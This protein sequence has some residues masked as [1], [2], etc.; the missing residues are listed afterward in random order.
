MTLVLARALLSI[1]KSRTRSRTRPRIY[2]CLF[3]QGGI[4][5]VLAGIFE[6]HLSYFYLEVV[7]KRK[8]YSADFI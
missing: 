1:E 7:I 5:G 4:L 6:C 2:R 3:I 8:Y